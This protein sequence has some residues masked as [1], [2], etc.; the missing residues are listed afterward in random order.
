VYAA[1]E[2]VKAEGRRGQGAGF[3]VMSRIRG[4]SERSLDYFYRI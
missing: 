3:Q 1:S 4:G 2:E